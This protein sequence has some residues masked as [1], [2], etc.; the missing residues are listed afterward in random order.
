MVI[1]GSVF[2]DN[3]RNSLSISR[4][5]HDFIIYAMHQQERV[6]NLTI[7]YT[8]AI[9]ENKLASFFHGFVLLLTKNSIIALSK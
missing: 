2:Y 5:T 6:D 3:C 9:V 4:Q 8:Y 1:E 7:T